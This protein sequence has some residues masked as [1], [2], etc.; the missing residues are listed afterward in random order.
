MR[1]EVYCDEA[2]PDLFTSEKPRAKYL[3][4]GALWLPAEL[5]EE[6]KAKISQN[7]APAERGA[8]AAARGSA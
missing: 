7:R 6:A 2:L 4:I 5:R 1:F 3:M 8:L